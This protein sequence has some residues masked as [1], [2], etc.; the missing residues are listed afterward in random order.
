[1]EEVTSTPVE[2]IIESPV[3]Q[4]VWPQVEGVPPDLC[5][6][7]NWDHPCAAHH[8]VVNG[9]LVPT[10][11]RRKKVCIVGYAE[12]SRHMAWFNDPD[13]EIWGVNQLYRFV[14]RADRWFQLHRNWN[15]RK[16]WA[17]KT[18][19][20]AWMQNAPIPIYMIDQEPSIPNSLAYPKEWVKGEL[21]VHEYFTS[22]IAF[23]LALAIAEGF[24]HIGLY[25][26]DLIIGREYH[27][28]KSCVEFYFGIAHARGV[29]YHLPPNSALLWQ[30]HTYGYDI[31]P[32]YGFYSLSRL[33]A[34]QEALRKEVTLHRDRAHLV[35]GR[36]EAFEEMHAK[37]VEGT[38]SRSAMDAK[39][40][41]VRSAVDSAL[42]LLYLHDGAFQE[43]QR[44]HAI[45]EVKS[46]GGKMGDA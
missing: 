4:D 41:E 3:T 15:D 19:L 8:A 12:N 24:E 36:M 34:R 45:L 33:S 11:P 6:P 42:N 43:V 26:I 17:E 18:D 27:F 23:M 7:I 32:D 46:R 29:A 44:M 30:S 14:P 31:E 9:V 13:C 28:E 16:Y 10:Q 25:G 1:V 35:Q 37:T 2:P 40:K 22:T 39:L 5:G 38:P 20:A 21:K